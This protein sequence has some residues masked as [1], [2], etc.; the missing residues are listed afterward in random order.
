M[1]SR[2]ILPDLVSYF[3][4]EWICSSLYEPLVSKSIKIYQAV[5]EQLKHYCVCG[6]TGWLISTSWVYALRARNA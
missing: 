3:Y 1:F 6:R 5:L 4:T 2:R